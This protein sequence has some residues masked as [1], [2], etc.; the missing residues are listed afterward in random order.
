MDGITQ[1]RWHHRRLNEGGK[2]G[3]ASKGRGLQFGVELQRD[4]TRDVLI[5]DD[6]GRTPSAESPEKRRPAAR[7]GPCRRCC[8]V[9][10]IAVGGDAPKS[11][12]TAIDPGD[13]G[14]RL[15]YA[16]RRHSPHVPRDRVSLTAFSS[17]LPA[18]IRHQATTGSDVGRL[19]EW[20]PRTPP[21]IT[22]CIDH[23]HLHPETDTEMGRALPGDTAPRV[24]PSAPRGRK[25]PHQDALTCSRNGAG[26]LFSKT[27]RL[28]PVEMTFTLLRCPR[29]TGLDQAICR[30]L[31]PGDLPTMAM[32]N[33]PRDC[34]PA[35]C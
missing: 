20:P 34:V 16:D 14:C 15:K 6:S 19:G 12:C 13:P 10:I 22:R 2:N 23:R 7:D 28:D 24:L 18:A 8:G 27:P 29:A 35:R 32:V 1:P 4:G 21:S 11:R 31:H 9:D 26:S 33:R 5:F 17:S 3:A 25:R 30:V